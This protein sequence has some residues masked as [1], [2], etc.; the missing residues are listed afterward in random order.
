MTVPH[1]AEPSAPGPG[2]P[3]PA[4]VAQALRDGIPPSS[5]LDDD[6]STTGDEPDGGDS[7]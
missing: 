4:D 5:L 7:G 6:A 3:G 2:E 1:P